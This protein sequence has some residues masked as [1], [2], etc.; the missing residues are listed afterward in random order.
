MGIN[1]YLIYRESY[2]KTVGTQSDQSVCHIN[3]DL[4]SLVLS[5]FPELLFEDDTE[6][7]ANLCLR[8]LHQCGASI[9]SIRSQASASLYLLMRQNFEIGNV[10]TE[11][12]A[13]NWDGMGNIP[14]NRKY[15]K[16]NLIQI[17]HYLHR[18][19]CFYFGRHNI[20]LYYLFSLLLCSDLC[21]SED[22]GYDVL[23][24]FGGTTARL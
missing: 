15:H 5:Q 22:A 4:P 8:L 7:C 3:D 9:S 13:C 16:K 19:D 12:H 23:E 10:R 14:F 18:V 17:K 20:L 6:Q 11:R 21:P 2:S 24:L 1:L